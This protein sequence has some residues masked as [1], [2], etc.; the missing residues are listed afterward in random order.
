M[1][2]AA[3]GSDRPV[4]G[5]GAPANR[6]AWKL[7]NTYA[8]LPEAFWTAVAPTPAQ[9]PGM[10]MFNQPLAAELGLLADGADIDPDALAQIFSGNALPEG[11]ASI[12][13]AY[14]GHQFGNFTMLGDGRALLVGEQVAPDGR[15]FDLQF[16]GSGP[17]PFSRQGDG[18]AA[19]G[20]MLREYVISEAMHALG[21]PTTR[22]LAVVATGEGVFREEPLPGAV[23][24]RVA[25]SHLRFG[26]F[27]Y[28]AALGQPELL[29]ALVDYAIDRHDP[30]LRGAP[31]PA[32]GLLRRVME[33]HVDLVLNWIRV[34]FVHG[35][36]NTDN[37]TIS[38]ETIDYG[39]CAFIDAFNPAAVFSSI[40]QG[41][42]YAFGAQPGVAQWNL[43]RLAEAL[44][45]LLDPD[46]DAAIRLAEEQLN[47]FRD[48][49]QIRWQAMMRRKL[50]LAA[51][52]GEEESDA[53][54]MGELLQW[55]RAAGADYA[56]T[57]R[58]L[59]DDD[60]TRPEQFADAAFS[61][62]RTRWEAR[63]ARNPISPAAARALMLAANPAVI[64]R[65]HM[66]EDAL[67][68]ATGGNLAPLKALLN[69]L[70]RPYEPF[71]GDP[72]YTEP[73]PGGFKTF[74]GT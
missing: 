7:D 4:S 34:G 60:V 58:A 54:L 57:F 12:A 11:A 74:C 53:A 32:L 26:T 23:L 56:N 6:L 1:T 8:R 47:G 38:G 49:Y 37:M 13:Q 25:A 63:R 67:A 18:R 35:V 66:V 43:A 33:R 61:E 62:W 39:P 45:P 52:D 20:P 50:G 10:I 2:D 71:H 5:R 59:S 9:A 30:D 51:I 68:A 22:S 29:Q 64:P 3:T 15:R 24:T 16:K 19:L 31:A 70:A 65:N 69:A 48:L 73:G 41:G 27:Q 28:A 36:M 44:L 17:T 40:D 46:K 55:M 14:A 21:V 72:A 42:R